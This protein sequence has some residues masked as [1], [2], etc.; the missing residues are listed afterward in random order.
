M[1]ILGIDVCFFHVHAPEF[2]GTSDYTVKEEI[3]KGSFTPH[4]MH[5]CVLNL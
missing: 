5:A 2:I 4:S 3:K 1:L